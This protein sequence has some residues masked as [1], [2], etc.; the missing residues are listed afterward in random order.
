VVANKRMLIEMGRQRHYSISLA[1][2]DR[3]GKD[4]ATTGYKQVIR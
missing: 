1:N 3:A 4:I 2:N